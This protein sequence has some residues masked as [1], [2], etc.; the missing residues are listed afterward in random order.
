M[1]P[2][3]WRRTIRIGPAAATPRKVEAAFGVAGWSLNNTDRMLIE[4]ILKTAIVEPVD[5]EFMP[6]TA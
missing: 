5:P 6:L 3:A 2:S 4:Q 1:S